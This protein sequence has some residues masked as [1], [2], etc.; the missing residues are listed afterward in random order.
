MNG[1]IAVI[2]GAS[3]GIGAETAKLLARYG[4][5]PVLA[6]R[7]ED[8]LRRVAGEI[9]GPHGICVMDVTSDPSVREAMS[10]IREQYGPVDIL[11][12]NAG[13]GIFERF[14][15]MDLSQ[16]QRMMDVNVYGICR[17]IREVLPDMLERR[18]GHIINIASMAGKIA[19]PKSSAYSATK[20]AVLG[21]TNSLRHELKGT[22]VMVSAVNPGPVDTPFFDIADPG[23][24]YLTNMPKWFILKPEQVAQGVLKVIRTRRRELD[25]PWTG[26]VGIRL[27][28][29]APGI[30]DRF[31]GTFLNRK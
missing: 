23:G 5:V 7:S 28:A 22:G 1:K 6:A 10:R 27:A 2:T 31:V 24:R 15:R 13:F 16:F 14:D 8:K 19:T 17:C 20:H 26:A 29:L 9:E 4:A 25:I 21:L 30:A 11:I 3:S 12:N 18:Q